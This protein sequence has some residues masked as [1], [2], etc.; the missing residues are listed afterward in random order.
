MIFRTPYKLFALL[1]LFI[2]TVN[3]S[4]HAKVTPHVTLEQ[5]SESIRKQSKGKVLSARTIR[6][7]NG[8]KL[9]KIKILT[10]DGRVKMHTVNYRKSPENGF[11]ST[12][13]KNKPNINRAP[14]RGLN[15]AGKSNQTTGTSPKK[16]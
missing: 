1:I 14:I 6:T 13:N 3:N 2:F 4:S 16:Q 15:N 10:P 7:I 5:A 11:Y 8:T 9:H 12:N